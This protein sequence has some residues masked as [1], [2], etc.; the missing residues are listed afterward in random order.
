MLLLKYLPEVAAALIFIMMSTQMPQF[1]T[2]LILSEVG[3]VGLLFLTRPV[4]FLETMVRWWPLLLAPVLA[5]ISALWSELPGIS[6][7]YG[8]QFLFTAFL[9]VLL[10]RLMTPTRFVWAFFLA[11]F[12]FCV[13]SVLSGRQGH[14]FEG[15]V[16]IGLTG[17]KNQMALA[18]QVLLLSALA[19]LMMRQVATPLRW[20]AVLAILLAL[21]LVARTSSATAIVMTAV[22]SIM[23]I[24]LWFSQRLP[25]GGR[26]AAIVGALIILAPFSALVP[27]IIDG[28]NYFIYDTLN[29]DPTLTGRTLLWA[30][31]DDLIERRPLLGYGYQAIWM[32]ESYDSIG[33]MR[34][35]GMSDG[36]QFHFHHQ[37]RQIAVDTGLVGLTALVGAII[38]AGFAA[39]RQF[40]LHPSVATSFFFVMF[41]LTV[42]RGF[43][44]VVL[45][46]FTM[47]TVLF[48]SAAAYAF[49]QP[50][51]VQAPAG[52]LASPRLR[53]A[54]A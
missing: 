51:Q 27:E 41:L 43:G 31:A 28:V 30:R 22:G 34:M 9:G 35:T 46:P 5:M 52:V 38:A 20:L 39:L 26:V 3:L 17:S 2:I 29:K 53:R 33:L 10:A 50:Q 23:L 1:G 4:V 44:D 25:P 42:A 54:A 15:M 37:F 8:A 32:G 14:S 40:I 13:L 16:P 24:G 19:V 12:V 47:H 11:M 21:Y 18:A 36:R 48:F 45:G 7:R 49:W 6:A